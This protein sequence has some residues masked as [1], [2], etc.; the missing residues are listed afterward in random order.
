MGRVLVMGASL[1]TGAC[2]TT[3][4]VVDVQLRGSAAAL[5]NRVVTVNGQS[6]GPV[7]GS[8]IE[9]ALCTTDRQKFLHAPLRVQVYEGGNLLS[10]TQ[11]TRSAC[12]TSADPGPEEFDVLRM[13]EDGTIAR[14][15]GAE[16]GVYASCEGP[17]ASPVCK[18]GE[19]L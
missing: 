15:F 19:W 14:D 11:V 17:N 2:H 8:L 16:A 12:A 10:D 1:G 3:A 4:Y 9:F 7:S 5:A 6:L 13:N 18:N